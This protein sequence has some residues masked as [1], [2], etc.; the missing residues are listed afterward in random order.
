[1]RKKLI[2]IGGGAA[3]IFCA[4]N[5]ARKAPD[6]EVIVLE[7]TGKLLSKVRVSGGGRCNVTHACFEIGEMAKRYP[8]GGHFV[9][10]AFHRWFTTDT[11][12]WFRERG[13]ELKTEEDGRMFPV[14]DDSQTIIDCLM[15]EVN[16][17]GV[18]IRVHAE[19][20]VVEAAASRFAVRLADGRVLEA[21]YLCVACGGYPKSESFDWIRGLGHSVEEPV[22]S[23]FTFNMPGDP[24]TKL[25]GV[26]VP[27]VQ[28]KIVGGKLV[29]KGPLLITHWGLSGPVVLRLSAWGAREL[30][31][32]GYR[33]D[34]QVNWIPEFTEQKTRE[35]FQEL[36][37]E[38][39]GQVV[40]TR[41]IFGLPQRL[42]EYFLAAAG[43]GEAVRWADLPAREQ[44]KLVSLLCAASYSIQGKTTFKEEFVTAGGVRLSEV[45]PAS[46]QSRKVPGLFFAGETLDVDGVTGGFNFQ[47][48]WTSGW[49]AADTIAG[50]AAP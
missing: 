17:Y 45:D 38:R 41:N 2:V 9:R 50:M 3:G 15:K 36:R 1:M 20:K 13:V 46:F 43:I 16:S 49:V 29:E 6:L 33:F 42:W 11:I 14:S 35:R 8:R 10:K 31:A 44:N 28:V 34:I 37:Y 12:G 27:E 32:S 40:G 18:E 39:A 7:K 30:A 24:I 22:P 26:T 21:D 19:V 23:L 5:A 4:V 47:H 48:A 25:M